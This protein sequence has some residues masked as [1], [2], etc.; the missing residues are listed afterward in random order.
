MAP[1]A[2]GLRVFFFNW[3]EFYFMGIPCQ[4]AVGNLVVADDIPGWDVILPGQIL[5]QPV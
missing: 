4:R 3:L 5:D 1:G 2:G